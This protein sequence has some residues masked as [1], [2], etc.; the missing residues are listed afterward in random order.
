[1]HTSIQL[2]DGHHIKWLNSD[3][4]AKCTDKFIRSVLSDALPHVETLICY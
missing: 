4:K 3:K 2:Y 1:M